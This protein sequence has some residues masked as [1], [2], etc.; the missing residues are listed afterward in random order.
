MKKTKNL[1]M[2]TFMVLSILNISLNSCSNFTEE[3]KADTHQNIKIV[4]EDEIIQDD[5]FNFSTFQEKIFNPRYEVI[6]GG[7]N[8]VLTKEK[9]NNFHEEILSKFEKKGEI[10]SSKKGYNQSYGHYKIYN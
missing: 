1:K 4:F 5:L 9:W 2:I 10:I 6:R 7:T 3:G 8:K